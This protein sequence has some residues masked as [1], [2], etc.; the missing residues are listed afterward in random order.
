MEELQT[1]YY[2]RFS[3]ID[4]PGVLSRISGVLGEHDISIESVIQKGREVNGSVPLVMLTHEAKE[5]NVRKAIARLDELDAL[6]DE[7]VVIRVE[8][9]LPHAAA[10]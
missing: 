2:F 1:A 7:T 10:D 9:G 4:R 6:T 5:S 3:A 8:R